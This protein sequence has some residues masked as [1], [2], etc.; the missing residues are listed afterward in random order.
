MKFVRG[1][2]RAF[3]N[4]GCCDFIKLIQFCK[5][6]TSNNRSKPLSISTLLESPLV[7]L[8]FVNSKYRFKSSPNTLTF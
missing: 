3:F 2:I 7:L 1:I 5:P 4:T 8:L 6:V